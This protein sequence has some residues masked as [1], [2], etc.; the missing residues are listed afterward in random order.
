[1]RRIALCTSGILA[2]VAVAVFAFAA[3]AAAHVTVNPSTASQG[4]ET[5]VAFRVPNETDNTNTVKVEVNIPTD[6]PIASVSIKPVAG[7][8]VQTEK[9]KLAA[10]IT[11]DDGQV[12]EAVSKITWAAAPGAGIQPGQFQEFEVSMGPMP[13]T[14]QIIFKTLQTYSDGNIVRWIDEP[15]TNGTEPEH[16][17][18]VLKLTKGDAA[19]SDTATSSSSGWGVGLGIT[20]L[21]VALAGVALG[22]LAYRKA[23]SH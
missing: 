9:T 6:K 2:G 4:D 23:T 16:P 5:V 13:E 8:T 3:P 18:P 1:M 20:A 14:D 10:P 22:F 12:S 21:I 19:S 15:T 17:A 11:T 7:W